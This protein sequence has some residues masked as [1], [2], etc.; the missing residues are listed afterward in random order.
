M[1]FCP[2]NF[3][4]S[5][6]LIVYYDTRTHY[7]L[8]VTWSEAGGIVLGVALTDDSNYAEPPE[9]QIGIADWKEAWLRA[10]GHGA[11]LR[12]YAAPDGAGWRQIGPVLDLT[13]VSDDYGSVLHFTGAFVGLC[14]Q[15]LDG[16]RAA[17]DF[18]FFLLEPMDPS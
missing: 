4:Q 15:D 7:Y 11:E 12:F 10:E 9:T 5:A 3:T 17:A 2:R 16:C 8:R 14:A 6:G 13:K 1:Q 18:D